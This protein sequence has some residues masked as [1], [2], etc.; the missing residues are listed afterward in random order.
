MYNDELKLR[1]IKDITSSVATISSYKFMFEAASAIECRLCKDICCMDGEELNEVIDKITGLKSK[2]RYTGIA[3]IKTYINWCVDNGVEGAKRTGNINDNSLDKVRTMMVSGPIHLQRCLNEI[4]DNESENTVDCIYRCFYWMA[5]G[6]VEESDVVSI[7]QN[8]IDFNNMVIKYNDNEFPI[9]REAIPAFR[10]AVDLK[11]FVYKHP[12]YDP[13]IRERC[14]GNE[15]IRGIRSAPTLKS[16]QIELSRRS[17]K[18]IDS[19]HTNMKLSYGRVWLS[20]VFYRMHEI[21]TAGYEVDF[22]GIATDYVESR[23]Y[24]FNG[25]YNFKTRVRQVEFG[26]IEDYNRWKAAYNI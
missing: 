20:G 11:C 3:R 6:G 19:G 8:N 24:N 21:E 13:V 15:V 12:N 10:N 2:S 14:D 23:D 7:K 17:K 22:S 4:C 25:K 9:Y 16:L 18:H 26:L 1:F 5:F